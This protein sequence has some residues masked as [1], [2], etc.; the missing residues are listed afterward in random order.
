MNN[1]KK[2]VLNKAHELFIEK[3]FQATSIQEILDNS[4]ISK[5]TFYNYFSS[6]NELLISIFK[7]ISTEIEEKRK[8][9]LIGKDKSSV[10]V[11]VQQIELLIKTNNQY[12]IISLFEEIHFINDIDLKNFLKRRR[13]RELNW[14]YNRLL[15]ICGPDKKAF[16]LDCSI[17]LVGILH[18][19]LHFHTMERKDKANVHKIVQ[20]CVNR[21]LNM[22][23][24]VSTSN[25]RLLDPDLLIK[26]LSN[27]STDD[28]YTDNN[29]I[30]CIVDSLKLLIKNA[31]VDS[32]EQ[33]KFE[34]LVDFIKEE[35][36]NS[37][38]PRKFVIISTINMLKSELQDEK[39]LKEMHKLESKVR[40]ILI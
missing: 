28:K 39:C 36:M 8:Q 20:Y 5:G 2:H 34:E 35:M 10:D 17:M 11:F 4:G 3:G 16:L 25:E 6:K 32:T 30:S 26:W 15:D 38:E 18:N 1:R 37:E 24:D 13:I 27:T 19:N 12:K 23:D 31:I 33:Q 14:I 40:S 21:I 7:N 22:V 9:L 29:N